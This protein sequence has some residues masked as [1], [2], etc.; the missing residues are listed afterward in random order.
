MKTIEYI[1]HPLGGDVD[2]NI[3]KVLEIIKTI[4]L[5]EPDVVPFAHWIVDA[6]AMDDNDAGQRRKGIGNDMAIIEHLKFDAC[7]LYG[8][9][10]SSGMADEA[11]TFHAMGVP[12]RAYT[13]G[14]A[15][16]LRLMILDENFNTPIF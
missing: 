6:Q 13:D 1:A 3:K 8:D 14:T 15:R 12:V 2:G 11:K 5:N 7:R 16:D 10:I 4:N 9:R